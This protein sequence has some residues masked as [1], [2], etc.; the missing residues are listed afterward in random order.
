[1]TAD[2]IEWVKDV[3]LQ[4]GADNYVVLEGYSDNFLFVIIHFLSHDN[5]QA[6]CEWKNFGP[7]Y[8]TREQAIAAC[9]VLA[10]AVE[11]LYE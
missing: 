11:S 7:R 8:E 2:V 1:M 3:P 5:Y 9:E 10:K 6:C 4:E